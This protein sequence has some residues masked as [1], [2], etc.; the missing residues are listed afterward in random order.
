MPEAGKSGACFLSA[1]KARL[2]TGRGQL[3]KP[4]V[5]YS[6]VVLVCGERDVAEARKW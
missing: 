2:G 3:W 4:A 5:P 6:W 1:Q